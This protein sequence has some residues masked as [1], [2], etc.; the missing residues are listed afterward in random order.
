MKVGDQL[1]DVVKYVVQLEL[2]G[3]MPQQ[4]MQAKGQTM[5]NDETVENMV[6]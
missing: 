2:G 1:N 5:D 4:M 3:S 6:Q